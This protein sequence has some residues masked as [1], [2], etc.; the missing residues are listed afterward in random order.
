MSPSREPRVS[1]N[2]AFRACSRQESYILQEGYTI[3][4]AACILRDP[5]QRVA[6]YSMAGGVRRRYRGSKI[7]IPDPYSQRTYAL[8][9]AFE[10]RED[11]LESGTTLLLL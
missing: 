5:L 9:W 11:I 1:S 3:R 6:K 10:S 2:T 7:L 4:G 8:Y